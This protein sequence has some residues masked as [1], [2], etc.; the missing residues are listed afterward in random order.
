M[1]MRDRL[2]HLVD[3]LLDEECSA[4]GSTRRTEVTA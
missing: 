3:E 1:L 2:E 4:F